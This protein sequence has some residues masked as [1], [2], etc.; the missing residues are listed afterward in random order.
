MTYIFFNF[1]LHN[2]NKHIVENQIYQSK[3]ATQEA[4]YIIRWIFQQ[5]IK[6]EKNKN[7][8]KTGLTF[9]LNNLIHKI[10]ENKGITLNINSFFYEDDFEDYPQKIT[11]T[12]KTMQKTKEEQYVIYKQ[13]S[14]SYV[15]FTKPLIATRNCLLC[16]IHDES[17]EGDV[18]GSVDAIIKIPIFENSNK[19]R[20]FFLVFAYFITWLAG[21]AVIIWSNYKSRNYFNAR[22]KDYEENIYLLADMMERRDT[23]TAGH[24]RR[25]ASYAT[26][27]AQTMEL[28]KDKIDLLFRAAMLHDIGKIEIPDAILL[29]PE[30]LSNEEYELIK[31]HSIFGAQLLSHGP[32]NELSKIVLYHHERYDGKGYPEGLQ[33]DKIPILSQ[34]IAVADT[35]DAITTSRAYKIALSKEETFEI[36][37]QESGHQF[38]P[39]IVNAALKA[40][41]DIS[42]ADFAEQIPQNELDEMRFCYYLKDQLTGCYNI[43]HLKALLTK[44]HNYKKV[45]AYR[46][47]LKNL[48]AYNKEFGWKK[49]DELLKSLSQILMQRYPNSI[50]I[51]FFGDNFL[52][53][54]IGKDIV[55]DETEITA[56]VK[57][58]GVGVDYYYIDFIKEN[59][60]SI[61]DLENT[62]FS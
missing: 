31:S 20:Y 17:K 53:L 36:L 16:H 32:F 50:V 54:N 42:I 43:N 19:K 23:Y 27:I 6:E 62:F 40:L 46:L 7:K 45:N 2:E 21:L 55:F 10:N 60:E 51:R 22:M 56:F 5:K 3:E 26:K 33:G 12:I 61:E 9:S 29:K 57:K 4:E 14:D 52:V 13:N 37:R 39:R 25:V 8:I 34:I 18:I 38:N 15:Y 49:G 35:F 28:S 11:K 58:F 30:K 44:L 47:T 48:T 41:E 1:Q 59:I 24:S